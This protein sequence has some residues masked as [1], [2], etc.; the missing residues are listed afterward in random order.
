MQVYR[1]FL[2]SDSVLTSLKRHDYH[3]AT[4][5]VLELSLDHERDALLAATHHEGHEC[6]IVEFTWYKGNGNGGGVV[7][8]E[9]SRCDAGRDG[10]F[11]L[12]DEGTQE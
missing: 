5:G 9:A 11:S 1:R 2:A 3:P 12:H 4:Q 7:A 6:K 8:G 10:G